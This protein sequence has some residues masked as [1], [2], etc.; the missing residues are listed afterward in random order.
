MRIALLFA[1]LCLGLPPK[2]DASVNDDLLSSWGDQESLY[3]EASFGPNNRWSADIAAGA[4]LPLG[5]EAYFPPLYHI[6]LTESSIL[7]IG[8][9]SFTAKM[10]PSFLLSTSV[11]RKIN[12][13][14]TLGLQ[15]SYAFHHGLEVGREE[16]EEN[17]NFLY[18]FTLNE[19]FE[20]GVSSSFKILEFTPLLRLG[21]GLLTSTSGLR[22]YAL[23][24]LGGFYVNQ[25]ADIEMDGHHLSFYSNEQVY[26]GITLGGGLTWTAQ[27]AKVSLEGRYQRIYNPDIRLE[28]IIPT[29]RV[30]YPF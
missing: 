16:L 20:Y 26:C 5:V 15:V 12:S 30:S 21:P 22:P 2:G 11:S 8:T 6:F 23:L 25:T 10:D 17:A 14:S 3:W 7:L 1:A 19:T 18:G 24:G 13:W 9:D 4:S 29:L 27:K 28:F